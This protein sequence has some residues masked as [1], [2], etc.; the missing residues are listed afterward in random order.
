MEPVEFNAG[1]Y[2]LRQLRADKQLDDRP[3]LLEA[4]A[5]PEHRRFVPHYRIETAEDAGHYI[6][7]RAAQ[8][9][10]DERCSWAVADPTTGSL[11]GEVGL[12]DLDRAD[13]TAEAGVWVHPAARGRGVAVT[14]VDVA[15]RYAF[16]T[17]GLREVRYRHT[18]DNL[19]SG[20]VA[21]RCGFHFVD[22]VQPAQQ[23]DEKLL[24][25]T[26]VPDGGHLP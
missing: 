2:F 5:D 7:L 11:L 12:K 23:P 20:T 24:L 3:A 22:L 19:A 13:G 9:R 15:L 17:L 25:W 1:G 14:A 26:R 21:A 4:F 8:W 18:D 16:G 6:D 10:R